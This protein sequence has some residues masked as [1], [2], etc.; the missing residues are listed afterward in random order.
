MEKNLSPTTK[1]ICE[2]SNSV[3]ATI[4]KDIIFQLLFRVIVVV[5]VEAA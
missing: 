5:V 3:K 4:Y 2:E 1:N